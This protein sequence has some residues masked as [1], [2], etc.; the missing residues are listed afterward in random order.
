MT[1]SKAGARFGLGR[2]GMIMSHTSVKALLVV[3]YLAVSVTAARSQSEGRSPSS[4]VLG[5]LAVYVDGSSSADVPAVE[6]VLRANVAEAVSTIIEVTFPETTTAFAAGVVNDL[7]RDLGAADY[8]ERNSASQRLISLGPGVL[9]YV[10][11]SLNSD[12][13]ELRYRAGVI[14]ES[15]EMP[16]R[17]L[18]LDRNRTL[19]RFESLVWRSLP[20]D[21]MRAAVKG[22]LATL[23]RIASFKDPREREIL[24]VL[25]ASLRY[26][27]EQADHAALLELARSATDATASIAIRVI[28]GGLLHAL[29]ADSADRWMALPAFPPFDMADLM[30]PLRPESYRSVLACDASSSVLAKARQDRTEHPLVANGDLLRDVNATLLQEH[31]DDTARQFF[32]SELRSPERTEAALIQL[33]ARDGTAAAAVTHTREV[34]GNP[35]CKALWDCLFRK[36]PE[37]AVGPDRASLYVWVGPAPVEHPW[38]SSLT[39]TPQD[40]QMS[41]DNEMIPI[42]RPTSCFRVERFDDLPTGRYQLTLE[43]GSTSLRRAVFLISGVNVALLPPVRITAADVH[44]PLPARD[45]S[46]NEWRYGLGAITK[47]I[48]ASLRLEEDEGRFSLSSY[49]VLNGRMRF[50]RLPAATYKV[51]VAIESPQLRATTVASELRLRLP[52][53]RGGTLDFPFRGVRGSI[54]P[55]AGGGDPVSVT[56][57]AR[58]A[59]AADGAVRAEWDAPTGDCCD[60]QVAITAPV[61]DGGEFSVPLFPEQWLATCD[62]KEI[63]LEAPVTVGKG[64]GAIELQAQRRHR[65]KLQVMVNDADDASPLNTGE[66]YAIIP[67]TH[68]PGI[69][70]FVN[71]QGIRGGI[72]TFEPHDAGQGYSLYAR[73]PGYM[74]SVPRF[75]DLDRDTVIEIRLQRGGAS[76]TGRIINELTGKSVAEVPTI[77]LFHKVAQDSMLLDYYRFDRKEH[78]FLVPGLRAGQYSVKLWGYDVV[79]GADFEIAE[80]ETAQEIELRVRPPR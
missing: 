70:G 10:K 20:P 29:D 65:F 80:G 49:R 56:F 34:Q 4:P 23:G 72:V 43:D 31:G 42:V 47:D 8:R 33:F 19:D 51:H 22:H 15:L 28:H 53:L 59:A 7:L 5:A 2:I 50:D 32:L 52:P 63:V 69:C 11:Q 41:A 58:F 71:S 21:T 61:G 44:F 3:C 55:A 45:S 13:P 36:P 67:V 25:L 27:P 57:S 54:N 48:F 79:S 75:F 17:P 76:L 26:S 78:R 12:D 77:G 62:T 68:A 38:Y 35:R 1:S 16:I 46:Q 14:C 30:D 39:I 37:P 40:H 24:A 74:N 60:T 18:L 64:F 66:V 6:T 73:A 9:P